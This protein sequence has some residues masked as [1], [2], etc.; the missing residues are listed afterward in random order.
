MMW[1]IKRVHQVTGDV[2]NK[3]VYNR[4]GCAESQV[5]W[6]INSS[7]TQ[8]RMHQIIGDINKFIYNK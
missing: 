7:T 1:S 8:V 5:M 4:D 2:V 3:F 6:S